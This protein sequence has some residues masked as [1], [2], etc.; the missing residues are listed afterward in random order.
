[1]YCADSLNSIHRIEKMLRAE[2]YPGN[3]EIHKDS[4]DTDCDAVVLENCDFFWDKPSS[5]DRSENSHK[6][7]PCKRW[8]SFAQ[9]G[10]TSPSTIVN[11]DDLVLEK[12]TSDEFHMIGFK[13]LSLSIPKGKLVGKLNAGVTSVRTHSNSI[14]IAIIGPIGSGKSSV[15]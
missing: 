2:I 6:K 12:S 8:F 15:S 7:R 3:V 11:K 14:E 9:S 5:G 13:N 4:H 10:S 1:M